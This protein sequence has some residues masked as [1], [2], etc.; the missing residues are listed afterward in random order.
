M[1]KPFYMMAI[2]LSLGLF[3]SFNSFA[4]EPGCTC[5]CVCPEKE[6]EPMADKSATQQVVGVVTALGAN[7]VNVQSDI[8]GTLYKLWSDDPTPIQN[9]EL[10]YRVQATFI[11]NSIQNLKVIGIPVEAEPT[12]IRIN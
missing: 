10:G 5:E 1:K 2:A 3:L 12:M 8:D 4:H 7:A 11:G 9:L 6:N